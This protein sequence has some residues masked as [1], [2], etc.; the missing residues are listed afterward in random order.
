MGAF[1][2]RG[3]FHALLR[4]QGEEGWEEGG[5]EKGVVT[6]SSGLFSFPFPNSG[7]SIEAMR[8]YPC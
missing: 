2:I 4:L 6:H 8:K 3:A 5:R 1:K 7:G